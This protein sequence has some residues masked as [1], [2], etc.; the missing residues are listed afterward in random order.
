MA[1]VSYFTKTP[2]DEAFYQAYLKDRLPRRIV[3]MHLHISDP[4]LI[5]RRLDAAEDWAA[6]CCDA[7]PIEDYRQYAAAFYPDS[8]LILHALP[9]VS[10]GID[11]AACN[12]YLA[13]LLREKKLDYALM[14]VRPDWSA[15]FVERQLVEGGFLG[16][17]P[18]PDLVSGKKGSDIAIFAYMAPHQLEV[19]NRHKG[20]LT[21]HI[22]RAGRLPDENN[23]RELK[24]LRDRYP[25]I[26]III[27]HVGRSYAV[28]TIERGLAGLGSYVNNFTYDL[29]AVLNP[30]V[31]DRVFSRID[32][33]KIYYGT[34]LPVF[35]WHGKRRWTDTAYFNL[36]RE[37]FS[38]NRHEEGSEAE[39][40]YT[41][42]LYEQLKNI[43]DALDRIGGDA[44][45]RERIFYGNARAVLD[46]ASALRRGE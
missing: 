16:F 26:H 20:I 6:E 28:D 39:A 36:A 9:P 14:V 37:H 44:A 21:L 29:A 35:L 42:F 45:L 27:A 24:E 38:W 8:E 23:L 15:E 1:M 34:D 5:G 46:R 40:Q 19:L 17:K 10:R 41:Y 2:V 22:P 4:A 3:D 11:H 13:R 33:D 31:L 30:A 12:A 32:L 18:Y 7:M 25:D 43:L